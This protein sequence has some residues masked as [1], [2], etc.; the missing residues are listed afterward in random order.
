MTPHCLAADDPM[1]P[2]GSGEGAITGHLAAVTIITRDVEPLLLLY[3]DG[4]GMRA[5]GPFPARGELAQAQREQWG[6]PRTM[7]WNSWVFDRPQVPDAIK[8]RVLVSSGAGPAYRTGWNRQQL[9]PYGMGFPTLDVFKWDEELLELGFERATPE[10]EVFDVARP[11]GSTYPVHESAFFGPEYL[12][13][14]AISRKEGMPQVGSFDPASGRGGP[15][16]A[17]QIVPDAN[18]M[19]AFLTQVL[20]LEMRSDR[21]W[22]EYPVPFRFSLVH[23]RGS[24]TGHVALVEYEE[25][26]LVP[27]PDVPPRP[28]ATGMVMWSFPVTDIEQIL[29]RARA[30][31]SRIVS[32]PGEYRSRALGRSTAATLEAPNGFLVEIFQ[33]D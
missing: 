31:G 13:I 21:T 29:D 3:R 26:D 24:T 7:V 2:L 15:A 12:R 28:P 4:L 10:V 23:A 33:A 30:H 14:I 9:G 19:I 25:K 17:T 27:G 20:D 32:G 11:D 8:L 5:R 6:L 1:A 16:Y 22:S 18:A